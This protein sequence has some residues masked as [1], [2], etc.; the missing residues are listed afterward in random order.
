[1][2]DYWILNHF[3]QKI[4]YLIEGKPAV[5][6]YSPTQL[7]QNAQKLGQSG[8]SLLARANSKV[9]EKGFQGIY[10]VAVT[11]ETP[12]DAVE[13]KYLRQGYSA[14]TG[15][16]YVTALGNYPIKD[17]DHMVDT[18]IH[19]YNAASKTSGQLPYLIAASPGWDSRPWHGAK[20]VVRQNPTPEKFERMLIGAKKLLDRQ[21]T[22]PKILMVEAWNEF[23]EGAYIEPTKKW[24][25]RYLETIQKVF[26]SKR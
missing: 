10:F 3:N 9:K 18:Y 12:S 11:N 26:G 22:S 24:G 16:N 17:Y 14:Y 7:D 25:M 6:I 5:F 13:T 20:A 2:V 19:I 4:Y 15:W 23:G 1:M 8:Q 21:K